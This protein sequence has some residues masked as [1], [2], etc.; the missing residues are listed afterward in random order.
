MNTKLKYP[1]KVIIHYVNGESYTYNGYELVTHPDWDGG[2][3]ELFNSIDGFDVSVDTSDVLSFCEVCRVDGFNGV[4]YYNNPEYSVVVDTKV[5]TAKQKQSLAESKVKE[6]GVEVIPHMSYFYIKDLYSLF[7]GNKMKALKALSGKIGSS[8]QKDRIMTDYGERGINF[9][10][11]DME[12]DVVKC[13]GNS[14]SF[15]RQCLI[16]WGMSKQLNKKWLKQYLE[17]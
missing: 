12:Y 14:V 10:E 4:T 11:D 13:Q 15:D 8:G 1:Y 6:Y 9:V 7:G 5:M 16:P 3:V 2:L 17:V